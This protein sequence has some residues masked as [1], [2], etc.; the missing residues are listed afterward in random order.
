VAKDGE[1]PVGRV[2]R[3]LPL[4]SLTA[5]TIGGQARQWV[6]LRK[7]G[8]DERL[9]RE[10]EFQARQ[11]G[12]YAEMMGG[13]KGV[14]M[15]VG[16]LLSFVDSAGLIPERYEEVW[17]QALAGLRADAP[18]MEPQQVAQ[19]VEAELGAEPCQLFSFFSPLPIAAASIGQVHA[20]RLDDGTDWR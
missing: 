13:M 9:A 16:Q 3:S 10:L 8:D 12:R 7:A 4:A 19:V 18:P 17:Q 20:A 1:I 5:R 15:K 2:R 11:A 6:R 14:I